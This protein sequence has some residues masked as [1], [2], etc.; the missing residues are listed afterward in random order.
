MPFAFVKFVEG[1]NK[2][3][4]KKIKIPNLTPKLNTKPK[5]IN[6]ALLIVQVCE[7]IIT[8]VIAVELVKKVIIT[9]FRNNGA[10]GRKIR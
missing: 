10:A 5:M 7:I 4:K 2:G 8:M 3:K 6:S 9:F 1:E